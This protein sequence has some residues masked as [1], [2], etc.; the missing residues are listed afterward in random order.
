MKLLKKIIFSLGLFALCAFAFADE[1]DAYID[2]I[3]YS[4]KLSYPHSKTCDSFNKIIDNTVKKIYTD[5]NK[6]Y[7]KQDYSKATFHADFELILENDELYEDEDYISVILTPY[8]F[9]GGAHGYSAFFPI[10][11]SIKQKKLLSLKDV[12]GKNYK[13]TL[14]KLS[15]EARSELIS[16][17]QKE[18]IPFEQETINEITEPKL[19][20]FQNFQ[21]TKDNLIIQ[22]DEYAAWPRAYGAPKISIPL[23]KLM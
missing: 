2:Q 6:I 21:I 11:Y 8:Y 18:N 13:T 17:A 15:K 4:V 5:F 20:N 9:T 10:N 3:N 22:F 1:N 16:Y 12:L 19:E 7:L 23:E 14:E